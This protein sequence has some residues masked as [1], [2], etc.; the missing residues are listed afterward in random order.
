MN[1]RSN[2]KMSGVWGTRGTGKS[3]YTKHL[4]KDIKRLVV[5]D[6]MREYSG[7]KRAT[8]LDQVKAEMVKDY[9]GFRVAYVPP[10]AKEPEALQ[11]LSNWLFYVQQPFDD[12][13][14]TRQ[15]TLVVEE[16][17]LSFSV[18]SGESRCP[19]FAAICS[20]GRHF[21]INVIGTSQRMA[22][23]HNTFRGNCEQSICFRQHA[24]VDRRAAS[25]VLG[26]RPEDLPKQ[27]F[28]YLMFDQ[29]E[30]SGPFKTKK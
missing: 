12:G 26:C 25:E 1:A 14:S 9:A 21:G 2:A 4:V 7:I 10:A 8:T 5:F 17:S 11:A 22:Q 19:R 18:K 20:I 16:M 29:G 24:P 3:T 15:L 13:H 28:S 27:N 23:V 30:L 6:P